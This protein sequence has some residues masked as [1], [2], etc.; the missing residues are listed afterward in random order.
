MKPRTS[1]RLLALGLAAAIALPVIAAEYDVVFGKN[2]DWLFTGYEFGKPADAAQTQV[3][4]SDLIE[5]SKLFKQNGTALM[6][7]LVP[8]KIRIYEEQLPANRSLDAYNRDLYAKTVA[9]LKAGGVNVVDIN[10]PYL[11]TKDRYGQNQLF[12]R[13]DTHWTPKGAMLAAETIKSTAAATP[14]LKAAWDATKPVKYDLNWATR[15]RPTRSRDLVNYLPPGTATFPPEEVLTFRVNRAQ[16]SQA[17]LTGAGDPVEVT[18][19]GSSFTN[20][21]TGYPDA[22][23]YA[24]QRDVLDISLPVDQGPWSGMLKYLGGEFKAT[25]PKLVIWEIPERELR[26][27]P[28]ASWREARYRIDNAQWL[29]EINRLLK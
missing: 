4:V 18:L 21:N 29:A 13:L 9:A 10:T 27:P 23:R 14:A 12:Y 24:L 19:L 16:A 3:T 5:A 2:K 11:A 25:K 28:A 26:S 8:S 7:M 1:F 6:I 15:P 20:A 17:G 22:V